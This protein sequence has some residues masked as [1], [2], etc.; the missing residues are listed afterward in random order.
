MI[1]LFTSDNEQFALFEKNNAPNMQ[2]LFSLMF[3]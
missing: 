2:K 1:N 3:F